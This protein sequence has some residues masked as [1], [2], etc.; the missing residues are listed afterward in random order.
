MSGPPAAIS[1]GQKPRKCE[2][3]EKFVYAKSQKKRHFSLNAT[4]LDGKVFSRIEL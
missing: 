2:P 1:Q 4:K 3:A